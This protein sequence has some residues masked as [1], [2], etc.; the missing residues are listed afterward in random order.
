LAITPVNNEQSTGIESGYR[1]VMLAGVWFLYYCFGLVISSIAP[2]VDTIVRDLQISLS[3]MGR[4]LGAWQ[5]V[6]LFSAI[7]LGIAIDRFGLRTS[8]TVAGA[9]IA[10]SAVL[11][12]MAGDGTALWLAVAV[13]GLGGPLISIG[14]PKVIA[15]WFG[16]QERGLAMGIYMT[17]PALGTVTSLALTNSVLMPWLDNNWRQVFFVVAT[18]VALS[19]VSWMV[20]TSAPISRQSETNSRKSGGLA[21]FI[22]LLRIPVVIAILVMSIGIFTYNHGLANWLPEILRSGGM[23]VV[24]A[25]FWAAIPTLT[26]VVSSLLIPRLATRDRRFPILIALF[27]C[28]FIAVLLIAQGGDHWLVGGLMMQGVARGAMMTIAILILMETPAV[29]AENM[30]VAGGLFFT[31]AEV[32]GVLGPVGIGIAADHTGGFDAAL[33]ILSF[34]CVL[35][36]VLALLI[37]WLERRQA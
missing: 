6:Y 24:D 20:I 4:I 34:I 22:R 9:I 1:W 10:I 3:M 25:G 14:A 36:V 11:R 18:V 21:V 8:L 37:K 27:I 28:A 12:G 31:A 29:G 33:L 23:S 19:A 35:L 30:G 17:G 13:F 26:G 32:G 15:R 2:L 5:L 16:S 7:P